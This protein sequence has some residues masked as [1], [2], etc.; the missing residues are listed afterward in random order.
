MNIQKRISILA[1]FAIL[2]LFP[3]ISWYYLQTGLNYRKE[4]LKDLA[5]KGSF[6][7][8]KLGNIL[9][10]K[11][12]YIIAKDMVGKKIAKIYNQYKKVPGFQMISRDIP[13]IKSDRWLHLSDEDKAILD[14]QYGKDMYLVD[15]MAV[16]RNYYDFSEDNLRRS[17]EHIAI[18]LPR[19]TKDDE[20]KVKIEDK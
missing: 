14:E 4:A 10:G 15:T 13:Q 7:H 6:N 1:L 11:T 12:T 8:T 18:I 16:L 17:I 2:V 5:T 19:P 20:F 9:R 3:A